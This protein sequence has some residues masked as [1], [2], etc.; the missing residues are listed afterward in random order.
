[1]L[2]IVAIVLPLINFCR[3]LDE[4]GSVRLATV[5]GHFASFKFQND[6]CFPRQ[7]PP[8]FQIDCL[9]SWLSTHLFL[10]YFSGAGRSLM[11]GVDNVVEFIH[12]CSYFMVSERF[13]PEISCCTFPTG[14]FFSF[15]ENQFLEV[16]FTLKLSGYLCVTQDLM[17]CA[18][19]E[20]E[21]IFVF[22]DLMLM[23]NVACLHCL[24]DDHLRNLELD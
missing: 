17:F 13:L 19:N 24:V 3:F 14:W 8:L 7:L 6:S 18:L 23:P 9:F 16:L 4:V 2:D 21:E 22:E 1:M 20:Y 5:S 11:W 15:R 12:I 10:G